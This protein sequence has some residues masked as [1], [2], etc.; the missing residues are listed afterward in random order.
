MGKKRSSPQKK[1][2]PVEPDN[3]RLDDEDGG[4]LSYQADGEEAVFPSEEKRTG[5][6]G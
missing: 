6:A 5:R 3:V 1:S 2:A 4:S